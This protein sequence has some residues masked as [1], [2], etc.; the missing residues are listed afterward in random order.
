MEINNFCWDGYYGGLKE[1]DAK[2]GYVLLDSNEGK[3]VYMEFMC[4]DSYDCALDVAVVIKSFKL[5][6]EEKGER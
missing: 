4:A 5:N 1:E 6:K 3:T 2:T